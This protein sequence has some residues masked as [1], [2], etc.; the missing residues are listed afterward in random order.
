MLEE[1]RLA[2]NIVSN[3][4]NV[5][6]KEYELH[7]HSAVRI[8]FKKIKLKLRASINPHAKRPIKFYIRRW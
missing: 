8:Q 2:N 1:K 3:S 5:L 4:R 7:H 6:N